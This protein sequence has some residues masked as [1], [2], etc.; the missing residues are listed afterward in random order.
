MKTDKQLQQDVMAEL[1]WEPSVSAARIGVEVKDGVVTLAGH[2]DSFAEKWEAQRAAQRVAGIK[3]LAVEMDVTLP[4]SSKRNDVDIARSARNVLDWGTYWSQ[5]QIK[6]MVEAGWITLTGEV[7]WEYQRQAA[8]N[9]V[10]G[11]MG[12]MGVSDQIVLKP[13]AS[14]MPIKSDIEAALERRIHSD[15]KHIKVG[16]QGT[17]VTLSGTVHSL[18][19]R[20][21]A[22]NSAWS[23]RGVRSVA[24]NL[25]VV[26]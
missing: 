3:G 16:V 25:T 7:D 13:N 8:S 6:V 26:Y 9:A 1:E 14:V 23:T 15:A 12:V 5:D 22:R 20:E 17:A 10:R 21:S 24:D 4:G 11:L 19:E 18:W 2:V